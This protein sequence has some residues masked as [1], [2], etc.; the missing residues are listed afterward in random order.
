MI[1][2]RL[3]VLMSA[4]VAVPVCAQRVDIAELG[5]LDLAY[6]VP[7]A[8]THYPGPPMA[9]EVSFRSGEAYSVV[10]PYRI[11]G[12]RYLVEPGAMVE[13][14]QA[15]AELSGTEIH[16]FLTEYEV[17]GERLDMARRRFEGNRPLYDNRTIDEARWIEI[18]DAYYSLNLEFEHLHHF[19]Q[20]LEVGPEDDERIVLKSPLAGRLLYA[21]ELTGIAADGEVAMVL[22]TDAVRLRVEVPLS[23][24]E[25]LESLHDGTCSLPVSGI[26][27]VVTGFF[28]RA[29][30]APLSAG[31]DY[32]PGE[33]LMVTPSYRASGYEVP[34]TALLQWQGKPALLM[35]DD[36]ALELVLVEVL[37]S[38]DD[39]YFI[40]SASRLDDREVLVRSVSAVQGVLLGLGGE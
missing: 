33:R 39:Y 25:G 12:I 11:Q 14:D 8:S 26:S 40:R 19:R 29:W 7:R 27:G 35:R 37:A 15:I 17:V 4:L 22:P 24:R 18:S 38:A 36:T 9:A 5:L 21:Q 32:L 31:C 20:L 2:N 3:V 1:F 23:R 28:L 13:K 6:A 34:G 30:S 10:T 16:H